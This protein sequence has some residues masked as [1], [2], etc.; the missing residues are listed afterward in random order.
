M[1]E[2]YMYYCL[3]IITSP[4]NCRDTMSYDTNDGIEN[5]LNSSYISC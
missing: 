4:N 2:T 5:S 1:I 3:F